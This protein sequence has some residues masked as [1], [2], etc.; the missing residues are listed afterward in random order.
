MFKGKSLCIIGIAAALMLAACGEKEETKEF[1]THGEN[2]ANGNTALIMDS[3]EGKKAPLTRPPEDARVTL[4]IGVVKNDGAAMALSHLAAEN[5]R[6]ESFEKYKLVYGDNYTDLAEQLKS[7]AIG[8]AVL[9]PAK[10]LD[11]YAADKSVKIL[12][13]ISNRNYTIIGEGVNSLS[14][15]SGKTVYVS[16]DDKTAYCILAKLFAY[17]GIKDCAVKTVS[18]NRALFEAVKNGEAQYALMQEP[19]RTMLK[20]D[21]VNVHQYDFGQDWENATEGSTYCTGCLVASNEFIDE[22]KA[23]IDYMLDDIKRSVEAINND[24]AA[25]GAN[26]VKYGLTDNSETAEEAYPGMDCAFFKDKQMRFI[27]NNMFTAFDNAGQDVL[28]TDVPD[29][30]FY[31]VKEP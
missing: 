7:K 13:S 1:V 2:I 26:A 15:L 25:Y 3:E 29:E 8:A 9:P 22:N 28:G 6:D 10:A 16:G 17:S 19:Y 24:T 5:E 18:D 30:G 31:M 4:T 23:A 11:L 21:G 20:K 12:A 14:D 27:M